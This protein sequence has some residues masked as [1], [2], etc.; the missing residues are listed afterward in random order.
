MAQ[1]CIYG[2]QLLEDALLHGH[3]CWETK[4]KLV[5]LQNA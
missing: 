2:I 3:F 5:V 4:Q 1:L